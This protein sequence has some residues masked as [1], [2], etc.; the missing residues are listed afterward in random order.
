MPIIQ[1]GTVNPTSAIV[2]D[3]Y[4]VIVPPSQLLLNG[5]ASN[6]VGL[7]GTSSWGPVNTPI[8]VSSMANF[9]QAFGPVVNRKYDMGTHAAIIAQQAGSAM[10]C[11]RVTDGTDVAATGVVGSTDVTFTAVNTGSYG[12]N[13]SVTLQNGAKANTLAAV[14][15]VPGY[16]AEVFQNIPMPATVTTQTTAPVSTS[17]TVDVTSTA[18]ISVGMTVSGTG[19]TGS[20][21]VAS[22]TDGTTLVLSAS[23]TISSGVTLTF[24]PA[25]FHSVWT[26]L[27]T[28][29]NN[30]Q[31]ALRPASAWITATAGSGT[32][33]PSLPLTVTLSGGTDGTGT[34]TS[35][36][37]VGDN[38]SP[39]TGMYALGSTNISILDVCDMD[40]STQWT[41][42]DGFALDESC[43]AIQVIPAGT[44]VTSAVS[45]KRTAGLDS[46]YSKLMHGDWCWWN[47][48]V[49]QVTR[50]VSPQAFVAGRLSNLRADQVTLNKTLYGI[51]GSQK[52]G[53]GGVNNA[54]YSTADLSTLFQAGIDV[55]TNPG[56]GGLAIWTCRSG[57][58][59]STNLTLELDNYP[60]LTNYIAKTLAAGMGFYIGQEITPQLFQNITATLTQFCQN[61]TGAGLL[62]SPDGSLPYAVQCNAANNP[63]SQTKIG[64]VTAS[65]Q[66]EYP[67][68]NQTFIVNLQG[69]STITVSL[70]NNQG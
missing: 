58:T 5:V 33:L 38:T 48:P 53:L 32:T 68:I 35:S 54:V 61:L 70:P 16:A 20:P 22:I 43:Y 44:S 31:N 12:N 1:S 27:A 9:S 50:L 47:D 26:A 8:S 7:V 51:A 15:G 46:A 17:S 65:V 42:V 52:S 56:A 60:T 64:I 69:G 29:V 4:V 37:L 11:V 62:S 66:A 34:I 14:V 63:D 45:L 24:T 57:H 59:S 39:P 30:G 3:L 55:V 2:P 23:Q 6:V 40:D 36:V 28:A 19:V 21:T 41:T 13:I 25:S 18:G 10:M 49:N 67:S